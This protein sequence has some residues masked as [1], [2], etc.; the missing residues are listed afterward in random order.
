MT[1]VVTNQREAKINIHGEMLYQ[2]IY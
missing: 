1:L 2:I